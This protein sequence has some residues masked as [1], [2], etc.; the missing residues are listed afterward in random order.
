ML[1]AVLRRLLRPDQWAHMERDGPRRP[2]VCRRARTR[3]G[4]VTSL[5]KD[6]TCPSCLAYPDREAEQKAQ[7]EEIPRYS[8]SPPIGEFDA[9][10]SINEARRRR[11]ANRFDETDGQG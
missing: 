2:V 11:R 3:A 9:S 6:T 10:W 1:K 8:M 7:E 5:W 4:G